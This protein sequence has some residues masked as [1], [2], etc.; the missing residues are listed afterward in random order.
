MF[1]LKEKSTRQHY[2]NSLETITYLRYLNIEYITEERK[3][4]IWLNPMM[5]APIPTENSTT[6]WQQ[7]SNWCGLTGLLVP[8]LSTNRES[9]VIKRTHI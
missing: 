8:N 2:K 9:R 5:E 1:Q 3:K 7:L 4:D 6:N